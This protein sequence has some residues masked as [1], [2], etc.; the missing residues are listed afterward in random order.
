MP[1]RPCVKCLALSASETGLAFIA[2]GVGVLAEAEAAEALESGKGEGGAATAVAAK[3]AFAAEP[4]APSA[5]ET[6]ELKELVALS[7][8]DCAAR[9][10]CQF[11]DPIFNDPA[12]IFHRI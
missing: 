10:V 11:N 6:V 12:F 7:A 4:T 3:A 8:A 2:V 5:A 9:G 1:V